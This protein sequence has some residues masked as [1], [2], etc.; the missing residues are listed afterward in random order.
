VREAITELRE[1]LALE[2]ERR[3]NERGGDLISALVVAHDDA[4]ALSSEELR[5][6]GPR[7]RCH[8]V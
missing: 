5:H 6:A 8:K 1:Y 4:E 7:I 2:I 3:R